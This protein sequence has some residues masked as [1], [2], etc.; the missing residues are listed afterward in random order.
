MYLL[1]I[2]QA[3]SLTHDG[4]LALVQAQG[5]DDVVHALG[6]LLGGHAA[7]QPQHGR[8]VQ[9]LVHRQRLVQQ[10]VLQI[11]VKYLKLLI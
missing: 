2:S 3:R 7:G 9:R 11:T 4:V 1:K 8:V 6:L 5:V 10:V